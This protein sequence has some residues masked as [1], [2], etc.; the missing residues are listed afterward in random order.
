MIIYLKSG[1]TIDMGE[2]EYCLIGNS[3]NKWLPE[4]RCPDLGNLLCLENLSFEDDDDVCYFYNSCNRL[5]QVKVCDI[6]AIA[7]EIE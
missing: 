1:Q 6:V 7:E 5:F 3:N 4:K 2:V